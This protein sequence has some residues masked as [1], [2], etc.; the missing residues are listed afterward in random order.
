MDLASR[1][2]LVTKHFHYIITNFQDEVLERFGWKFM[3]NDKRKQRLYAEIQG[4][5]YLID[6]YGFYCNV[7]NDLIFFPWDGVTIAKNA[8]LP[9]RKH[10]LI[11]LKSDTE[12]V[13]ETNATTGTTRR[14]KPGFYMPHNPPCLLHN[15][16]GS[17]F[18]TPK[19]GN[20]RSGAQKME[21]LRM[22]TRNVFLH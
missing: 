3:L 6:T 22:T 18:M 15:I 13:V 7:S 5:F 16:Y 1:P 9:V 8:F 21:D 14:S 17:D 19:K 10:Q 11:F 4:P 20:K 12:T 2:I